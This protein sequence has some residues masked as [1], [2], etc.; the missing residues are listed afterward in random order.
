MP[1]ARRIA[2]I[3]AMVYA[4][5]FGLP[6]ALGASLN[7]SSNALTTFHTCVLSGVSSSGT[8]NTDSYV[9]Q[10]NVTQ[11]N[12]TAT[13]MTVNSASS[14]TRSYIRFDLTKCSPLIPSSAAVDLA[15]LRL[16]T[17]GVPN[18]CRTQDVFRVTSAWTESAITWN[19][20]PFGTTIN[21]PPSAQATGSM[22]IGSG[23]AVNTTNN[24][25]VTGWTVTTDVAAFVSG[26]TNNGWMIRDDAEGSSTGR[27]STYVTRD[28]SNAARAP[29]LVVDYTT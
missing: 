3:A 12:G 7:L 25:Y 21:N 24:T 26:T 11:N 29:Q 17:T 1:R 4:T 19:T 27:N 8:V 28:A 23:C 20:Q 14:N 15:T 9:N 13:T 5:G 18:A 16:F 22:A 2:V 6:A 10:G